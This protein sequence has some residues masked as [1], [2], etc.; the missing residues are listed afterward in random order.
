MFSQR[1]HVIQLNLSWN[2]NVGY[3]T[4]RWSSVLGWWVQQVPRPNLQ[5]TNPTNSPISRLLL[6]F[7]G[8]PSKILVSFST[9]N[10]AFCLSFAMSGFMAGG[11]ALQRRRCEMTPNDN[12]HAQK[13]EAGTRVTWRETR[14]FASVRPPLFLWLKWRLKTKTRFP[15]SFLNLCGKLESI[16]QGSLHIWVLNQVGFYWF[17]VT[18]TRRFL[19]PNCK[20]WLIITYYW[21]IFLI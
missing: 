20:T 17:E 9:L 16:F 21:K 2:L 15:E 13:G 5:P 14:K 6:V 7:S 1:L 11:R 3:K 8:L 10:V 18:T 19:H 12:T 4:G